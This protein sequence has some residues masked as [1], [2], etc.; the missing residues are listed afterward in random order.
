LAAP[1]RPKRQCTRSSG[2]LQRAQ[3]L[4]VGAHNGEGE[5]LE[6][7]VAGAN[8]CDAHDVCGCQDLM[9]KLAH[10]R[11]QLALVVQAQLAL[12]L[13]RCV[14]LLQLLVAGH[15]DVGHLVVQCEVLH[16]G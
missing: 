16:R 1:L 7:L 9:L 13:L 6:A 3:A 14:Q 12:L 2:P 4:K 10:E 8:A 5:A 11:V 15:L